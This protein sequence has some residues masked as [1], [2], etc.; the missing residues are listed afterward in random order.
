[1]TTRTIRF[2]EERGLLTPRRDGQV[3]SYS[4]KDRVRLK[5]ILRGK[6]LGMTLEESRELIDM[7]NPQSDNR[8]QLERLIQNISR[9]RAELE[10]QRDDL[11]LTLLELSDAEERAKHALQ[12]LHPTE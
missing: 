6:R 12:Q 10:Q 8:P 7:Y 5:L 1:M 4:A 3:R 11:Q 9:R 2:Y